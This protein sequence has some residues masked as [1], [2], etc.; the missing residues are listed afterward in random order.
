[1]VAALCL[2]IMWAFIGVESTTL[3][4]EDTINP[5]KIIARASIL[6]TLPALSVYVIA[7]FGIMSLAELQ[8]STSPFAD[9]AQLIMGDTGAMIIT[10]GALFAIG[11]TLNVCIMIVGTIMLVGARD[12]IFPT[13]F[14]QQNAAG[15][16]RQH[17]CFPVSWQAYCCSLI[18]VNY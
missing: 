9:P 12:K 5:T 15:T 6:G 14:S 1:M 10:I 11:G 18:P 2:L 8:N 7:M 3:P 13:Y 17:C 4:S 16:P